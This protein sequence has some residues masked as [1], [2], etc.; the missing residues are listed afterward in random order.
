MQRPWN[1]SDPFKARVD[2]LDAGL[3]SKPFKYRA[4]LRSQRFK[5]E[6]APVN[7]LCIDPKRSVPRMMG[8]WLCYSSVLLVAGLLG[9]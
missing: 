1:A 7:H 4:E 9:P 2:D 6:N 3:P 8:V 5:K